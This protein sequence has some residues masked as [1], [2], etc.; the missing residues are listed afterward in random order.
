MEPAIS[1]S[2]T[3]ATVWLQNRELTPKLHTVFI[4]NS[5]KSSSAP[6]SRSNSNSSR[7]SEKSIKL[8]ST[9]TPFKSHDHHDATLPFSLSWPSSI[10]SSSSSS[11]SL[12]SSSILTDTYMPYETPARSQSLPISS[13]MMLLDGFFED[14]NSR[15]LPH[16]MTLFGCDSSTLSPL[17]TSLQTLYGNNHWDHKNSAGDELSQGIISA[18]DP[19]IPDKQCGLGETNGTHAN[20]IDNNSKQKIILSPAGFTVATQ[21]SMCLAPTSGAILV[22]PTQLNNQHTIVTTPNGSQKRKLETNEMHTCK[23]QKHTDPPVQNAKRTP[24]VSKRLFPPVASVKL[25]TDENPRSRGSKPVKCNCKKSRCQKLYCECLAAGVTC[26][27]HCG[28]SHC[29]NDTP[30]THNAHID[31][32]RT[33]STIVSSDAELTN[34]QTDTSSVHT[35]QIRCACKKSMCARNYCDCFRFNLACTD[36]CGCVGCQNNHPHLLYTYP[37][38]PTHTSS[39]AV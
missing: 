37:P 8:E 25:E 19:S 3:R 1:Y 16:S 26:G 10:P 30:H 21:T 14:D 17:S 2:R 31:D 33:A 23:R 6:P 22:L 32:S 13:K 12:Q 34:T 28:C 15:L 9:F 7:S 27:E 35:K 11:S 24:S 5:N 38:P 4:I 18:L 29:E 20:S 39:V 36:L